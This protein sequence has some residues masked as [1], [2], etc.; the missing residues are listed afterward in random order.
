MRT[1]T[2]GLTVAALLV[3]AVLATPAAAQA[4]QAATSSQAA[5]TATSAIDLGFGYSLFRLADEGN[6]AWSPVGWIFSAS[7][8]ITKMLN[9]V[10][11]VSGHY[12]FG[13]DAEGAGLKGHLF[14]GGVRYLF[15]TTGK[16]KPW[17]QGMLGASHFSSDTGGSTD[18][19]FTPAIGVDTPLNDK[20]RFRAQVDFPFISGEDSTAKG[21][22]IG[23]GVSTKVGG[24]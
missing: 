10:G 7:G 6:S 8:P 23:F 1:R 19:V 22:R 3:S 16:M 14:Q 21:I 2:I 9:W 15:N 12:S 5:S 4:R 24:L 18:F 20:W 11:D 13:G 17:I